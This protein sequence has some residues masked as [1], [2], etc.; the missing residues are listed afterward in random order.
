MSLKNK[1]I[2]GVA[3]SVL[4]KLINQLG[5]I[6]VT[7]YL[8]KV[9]GPEAFGLVGMLTIFML[10]AESV[11]NNGFSQ[12]LVQRSH[13]LTEADSSTIFYVS[14]LWSV[15][16]YAVLYTAA[17]LIANFYQ[18]PELVQISRLLFVII[19]INSLTVVARAKL[20]IRVDF[21]SQGI[22]TFVATLI[23]SA[24][25]IYLASKSYGYWAFV[26]LL[27]IKALLQ[28]IGFW[29]FCRWLPKL[30]FSRD[31]FKSLFKF[32]SNLMLAGFISTLV[33]NLYVAMIGRYFNAT[34][35]GYFTQA[36]NLTNL[37]VQLISSTL[38]GVTYPLLT[39]IKEQQDR[40]VSLYRQLIAVT[41]LVSLPALVGFSAVADSFVLFFM[42]EEWGPAIP[43]IQVLCFARAITPISSINMNILN[44]V[45]RS[46]LFL[47]VDLSKL[48]MTVFA[49][50]I[51]IPYGIQAVAWAMLTTS[52]IAYFINSYYPGKLYGFGAWSQLKVAKNYIFSATIMFLVVHHVDFDKVLVDLILSTLLGMVIYFGLLAILKDAMFRKIFLEIKGELKVRC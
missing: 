14:L 20:I 37:L 12:A 38:Q 43:I 9:I 31:S 27:L 47:K 33:N 23:S 40:L 42:G 28:N 30:R 45:G 49:L 51:S 36:T 41:M 3:W 35:V 16:I 44:A 25:A 15:A 24:V 46:D 50:F 39:S 21:K 13:S 1:A 5:F 2:R 26:W 22:A 19:I 4:D 10:L 7:L 11:V 18:E 32:G 29:F 6:C 8:A 34:S 52:C 17:P 48:P